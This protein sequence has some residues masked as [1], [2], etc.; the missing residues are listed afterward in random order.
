MHYAHN[1]QRN[2]SNFNQNKYINNYMKEKYYSPKL[3]LPKDLEPILKQKGQEYGSMTKYFLHL[4]RQDL[5]M[6]PNVDYMVFDDDGNPIMLIE[7]TPKPAG[8][9]DQAK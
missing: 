8:A 6:K 1:A 9:E 5:K 2:M 7:S 4:I 3:S